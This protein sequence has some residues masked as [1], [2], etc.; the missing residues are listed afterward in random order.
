MQ[1]FEK[2]IIVLVLKNIIHKEISVKLLV[3]DYLICS[4]IPIYH[5]KTH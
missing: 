5:W 4:R 1:I 3:G 2:D